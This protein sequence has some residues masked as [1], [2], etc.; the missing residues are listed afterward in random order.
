MRIIQVQMKETKDQKYSGLGGMDERDKIFKDIWK[1]W[2]IGETQGQMEKLNDQ[3][4][5]HLRGS[6]E[7][8]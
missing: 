7:N 2:K 8:W 5:S 6:G 1:G 3:E 4:Y